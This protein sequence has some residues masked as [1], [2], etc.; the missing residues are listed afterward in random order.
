MAVYIQM[1]THLTMD[2][3]LL[4]KKTMV[5][6]ISQRDLNQTDDV[7]NDVLFALSAISHL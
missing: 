1:K 2:M 6:I 5:L 4:E 7:E 3:Q